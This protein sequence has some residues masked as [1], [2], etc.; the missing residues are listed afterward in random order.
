MVILVMGVA[1]AGKT[2]VGLELARQLGWA[3]LDA[4]DR[5]PATNVEKMRAGVPLT[6]ADREPW[7]VAVR[8]WVRQHAGRGDDVVLACSALK[9][10][11]REYLSDV[12]AGVVTI[13]LN[14]PTE[15]LARR[16]IER[17]QHFAG[18]ELLDSQQRTLELPDD[19]IVVDATQPVATVV[20]QI[21]AQLGI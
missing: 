21:R 4:D 9:R 8:E 14:A 15:V 17:R 20:D 1:G 18:V 3:F 7:L 2:T 19:A 12:D 13:L 5:H 6:D 16:L 11:Y 10:S